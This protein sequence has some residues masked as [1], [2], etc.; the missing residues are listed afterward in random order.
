MG[1][2]GFWN[3]LSSF[4]TIAGAGVVIYTAL[5]AVRQ[6]KEMTR[7]RNLEAMLRVYEMI[8]SENARTLRRYIY[9]SLLSDPEDISPEEQRIIEEVSVLFDRVGA[10]VDA[11]LVPEDL[12]FQSHGRMISRIWDRLE[13]YISHYR[14]IHPGHVSYF[15]SLA[16]AARQYPASH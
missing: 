4:A 13:P 12:L 2:H 1:S 8:S 3:Y 6:L 5:L 16:R 7:S 10:L 9:E 15:E 11:G 14:Q